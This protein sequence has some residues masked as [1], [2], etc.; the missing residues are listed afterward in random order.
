VAI[1]GE[2]NDIRDSILMLEFILKTAS[3]QKINK[4]T[5]V[6]LI[7]MIDSRELK[8]LVHGFARRPLDSDR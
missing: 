7:D 4:S 3:D 8:Q 1:V 5:I 6:E 2:G